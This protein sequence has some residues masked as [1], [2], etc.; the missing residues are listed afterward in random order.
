MYLVTGHMTDCVE[1]FLVTSENLTPCIESFMSLLYCNGCTVDPVDG[2]TN[3]P[4][5]HKVIMKRVIFDVREHWYLCEL[6]EITKVAAKR[7]DEFYV[8]IY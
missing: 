7:I 6:P 1:R 5:R 4:R 8:E 3:K 2:S